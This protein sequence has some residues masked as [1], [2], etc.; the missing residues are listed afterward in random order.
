MG[1]NV[2]FGPAGEI[3]AGAVRQ[4]VKAALRQLSPSFARQPDVEI[5]F[6]FHLILISNLF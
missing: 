4:K 3:E 6:V 5:E 2:D 1:K